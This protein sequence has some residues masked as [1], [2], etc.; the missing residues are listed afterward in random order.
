[1][2]AKHFFTCSIFSLGS[3]ILFAQSSLVMQ[4]KNLDGLEVMNAIHFLEQ[5]ALMALIGTVIFIGL[6]WFCAVM[7]ACNELKKSPK[8][9]S[10]PSIPLLILIVGWSVFCQSCSAEQ[11]ARATQYRLE[12]EAAYRNCPLRQQHEYKVSMPFS[13]RYYSASSSNVYGPVFCKHCGYKIR[14]GY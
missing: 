14:G 5:N 13:N 2:T 12:A 4:T 6:S 9:S 10:R 1:M 8:Q 7:K 11:R 3:N